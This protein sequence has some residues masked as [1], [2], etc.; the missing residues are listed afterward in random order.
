MRLVAASRSA[1]GRIGGGLSI[2]G[3]AGGEVV[4]SRSALRSGIGIGGRAASALAG[5]GVP[6]YREGYATMDLSGVRG[7]EGEMGAAGSQAFRASRGKSFQEEQARQ[8]AAMMEYWRKTYEGK[9]NDLIDEKA[10]KQPEGPPWLARC[11]LEKY[12]KEIGVALNASL[13][14]KSFWP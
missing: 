5:I 7:R 9:M 1:L 6:G 4:A 11:F 12:N 8:Q 2:V 14:I 10:K 13:G 3:E